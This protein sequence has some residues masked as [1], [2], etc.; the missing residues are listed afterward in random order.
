VVRRAFLWALLAGAAAGAVGC[1]P[2]LDQTVSIVG[3]ARVIA[4]QSEPPEAPPQTV[5]KY[6]VLAADR[7]G[8]LTTGAFRWD[9]CD[10]RK[11]LAELGPV[12]Q[13]CLQPSGDWFVPIGSGLSVMGNVPA[14]A[15]KQFGPD[16]PPP[17]ENQPPGRPVDTDPTGGYYA[18]IRLLSPDGSITMAETRL[19]CGVS[20]APGEVSVDFAHRYHPNANPAVASLASVDAGGTAGAPL[21]TS[22]DGTNSV[23]VGA[24]LKL[25]VSWSA[26]CPATADSCGDGVCGPDETSEDCPADCT[27]PIPCTGAERF[28]VFDVAGQSLVIQR[29]SIAVGW[30]ATGGSFDEDRTGRDSSDTTT[31]SDNVW[32]AP[33]TPGRAHLWTVLRDD[34]GGVGWA[35]YV[36]A[37]Q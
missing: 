11:P 28:V 35:E 29:E 31:S 13:K 1:K 8:A 36:F 26:S 9:F 12:S 32:H 37:V 6:R 27:M 18:P 4:V 3:E 20:G 15:C 10:A 23:A 5:V 7:T 30:Y 24:A 14:D 33:S 34:R 25:R 22:G 17:V 21:V 2:D 16:V 19:V